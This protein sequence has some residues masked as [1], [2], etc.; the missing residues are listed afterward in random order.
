MEK[1]ARADSLATY[2]QKRDFTATPE[3]EA[4]GVESPY[5]RAFVIQKHWARNLHYDFRF[6]L[7][8]SMKSWAVPKGPSLDPHVK[9]MAVHVEDHPISYNRFEGEIPPKQYG[10]GRVIIWDKGVWTPI[11]DPREGYEKGH[12]KFELAGH[13]LAGRWVLIRMKGRGEKQEP[14]L[15]IKEADEWA[16]DEADYSVVDAEPDS[17]ADLPPVGNVQQAT[18]PAPTPRKKRAGTAKAAASKA[19]KPAHTRARRAAG[20][21][22][23]DGAV[24]AELPRTLS[25]QLAT[26]A[27]AVPGA[28]GDW[29]YE[30]KFDGYRMLAQVDG[31]VVRLVTR[32]GHDWS[33]KLASVVSAL[34]A[35]DLEPAWLDGEIVLLDDDARPSFQ[36]L[37]G[38]FDTRR[39]DE[40]VY[41]LF[42]LPYYHGHDL[43]GLPLVE[44][45]ALLN[46]LFA[47]NASPSLRLSESFEGAPDAVREAA[48]RLSLEGVIAKRKA[49]RYVSRRSPDWLKLKCAQRQEFVIGGYTDPSGARTG[50]GALLLGVHDDEGALRYAGKVG[51]GFDA[52][53]LADLAAKLEPLRR[54]TRPF[55]DATDAD[56]SAHWV[57]PKLVAEVSFG[58][59]TSAGRL[60]HAVFKGLRSDK[61]ASAIVRERAKGVA[62]ASKAAATASKRK[63]RTVAPADAPLEVP[64]SH[65]DRVIDKLTGRTKLDVVSYYARIAPLMMPHLEARPVSLVRAP[66]GIGGELFFQKHLEAMD[67]EGL[68]ALD[69]ALD[70]GHAPL[71]A[72]AEPRGLQY[73]AQMNV[74]EFHT[75]NATRDRIMKP[76][77][78]TFDLDP[79]ED[80]AWRAVIEAAHVV[81]AFLE[82]L[83][84]ASFLKTS[85][86]KG[87]HI[88]VP[89]K[90]LYD[91]DT[92]KGFTQA[93]VRHLAN[94]LPQHFSAKSGPRNRVGKIYVDYLRNGFGATTVAAWSLRARP[95]LGVSVPVG[96]NELDSL[97]GGA[98]WT[99]EN[100]DERFDVGN[101]P[102][103]DYA[104]A[105]QALGEAMKKLGFPARAKAA[106]APD[107]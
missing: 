78:M 3:P 7:D 74:L 80:V 15:L 21:S 71:V 4:G 2:R 62:S 20:D 40:I 76:D 33:A 54:K 35:L 77:R 58:E 43:R 47:R 57:T 95:G 98:H 34:E 25:P 72:V 53:S 106:N 84:L 65:A 90:R 92:A 6:E 81:S 44:R 24:K 82:E 41:Y 99:L 97:T 68:R 87:L 17:V 101:A 48:C 26:L 100:V 67:I 55:A 73:A 56:R 88:V 51:T 83:G 96:W 59:W 8:G 27:D 61:P 60:R 52:Q 79:G 64:V 63:S 22:L 10:A 31:G 105:A 107:Q 94:T 46:G 11:G 104:G 23:P 9:R 69:P 19:R 36:L 86:G 12:L 50:F 91:W 75:W 102:W 18:E 70:P 103:E 28:A 14:W 1:M 39:T 13:K 38:A 85:G 16:R 42:D 5:A 30:I 29:L 45:Q 89:I 32:N 93:V 49:S 66:A 37:Q